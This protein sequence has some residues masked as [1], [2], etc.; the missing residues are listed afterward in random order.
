MKIYK[1]SH[2]TAVIGELFRR[3]QH[4]VLGISMKYTRDLAKAEDAVMDIF[5]ELIH[6]LKTSE[7]KSFKPWLGTVTR[8]FLH[9][10]FRKE[11]RL[12]TVSIDDGEERLGRFMESEDD[13]TPVRELERLEEQES[14]LLLALEQLK[15]EQARCVR[16]F[17]LEKH[18][19]ADVCK[20]TGYSFKDVKSY[21]QNGKRNLKIIM[22]GP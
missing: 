22:E 1:E 18:S 20:A 21:I 10:K 14:Q 2:D 16:L 15:P 4:L 5:E 19:Y 12:R 9:R 8:N 6:L 7:I 17:Y 13:Q 3:Y 11:S